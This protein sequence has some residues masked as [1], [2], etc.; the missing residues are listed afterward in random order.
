MQETTGDVG[1]IIMLTRLYEG[2]REK[3]SQYFPSDM[4]NPTLVLP[5]HEGGGEDEGTEEEDNG[6]P[7]LDSPTTSADADSL[8]AGSEPDQPVPPTEGT[9]EAQASSETQSQ[10]GSVTLLSLHY[11]STLACEVRKLRLTIDD[12]TKEIFH[13]LF[14]GWPDYGKPEAED[15][16]ALLE[17]T[18]VSKS[19]AGDSPRVVHCSAG[20]GRTGTWIAL[21]FLLQELDAGRMVYSAQHSNASTPTS[22]PSNASGTW[23]RSGPSKVT[24]PDSKDED[25]LVWETVNTLREQRMMMVMNELQY[26]FLY[27]V[28]KDAF[29]E[30]YAEKETGPIVVEAQEPSP[31]VARKKSPF[32]GMFQESQA[33]TVRAEEGTVSEVEMESEAETEIIDKVGMDVDD[34]LDPSSG[35][36]ENDENVEND[37]YAAVG[38]ENF[39]RG[40]KQDEQDEVH[41]YEVK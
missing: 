32:G 40:K 39:Q 17:L 21:D 37:P 8:G 7:F 25:D 29:I 33:G 9:D 35:D 26:S 12:E 6:D 14:N 3:C 22:T 11:D 1:V 19:V 38:P 2:H 34:A 31:K 28:L 20:V 30:K 5:A 18:K 41:D 15:R 24:T 10:P 36:Q 13:Y 23:G 16:L 4:D 27:E